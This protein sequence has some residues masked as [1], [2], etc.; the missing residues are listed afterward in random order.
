[1]AR[2]HTNLGPGLLAGVELVLQA[3]QGGGEGGGG[4]LAT[5]QLH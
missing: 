5:V 1:M 2:A 3:V 4:D